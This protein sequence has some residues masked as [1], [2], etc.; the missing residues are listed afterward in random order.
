MSIEKTTHG[1]DTPAVFFRGHYSFRSFNCA[2]GVLATSVA[3]FILAFLVPDMPWGFV[4]VVFIL[5]ALLWGG[6]GLRM[7]WGWIR[8]E[9]A[10]VEIN[11]R[12]IVRG[13]NF[14]PWEQVNSFY[15]TSYANGVRLDFMTHRIT[16]G[17]YGGSNL[18]TTPLLTNNQY[19][20]LA[21]EL[22]HYLATEYPDVD[23]D[24]LPR[25]DYS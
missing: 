13:K 2:A 20:E 9:S 14:W 12:G 25:R 19:V 7:L 6:L 8:N 24:P 18:S 4:S 5:S 22:I 17:F 10:Y 15:G 16:Y 1:S 23:V 11:E 3:S 21:K